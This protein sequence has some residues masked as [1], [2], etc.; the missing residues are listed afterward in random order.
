[1]QKSKLYISGPVSVGGAQTN[2]MY[3][4]AAAL[5]CF[6]KEINPTFL[7]SLSDTSI[8]QTNGFTYLLHTH[9]KP[10]FLFYR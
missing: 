7:S 4:Y 5:L 1:M 8:Q 10:V 2:V 6:I 3:V 9:K